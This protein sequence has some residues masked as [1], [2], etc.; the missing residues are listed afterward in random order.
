M[1]SEVKGTEPVKE[2]DDAV[3]STTNN[4]VPAPP[5]DED[6]EPVAADNDETI[7]KPLNNHVP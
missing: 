1:T 4:H 3:L 2:T 5:T 7:V 6:P